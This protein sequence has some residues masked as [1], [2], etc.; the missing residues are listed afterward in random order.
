VRAF[1]GRYA[2]VRVLVVEGSHY[3]RL[4]TGGRARIELE[5]RW[6]DRAEA[7]APSGG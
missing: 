6:W 2:L 7:G 3:G 4:L 1:T 5:W